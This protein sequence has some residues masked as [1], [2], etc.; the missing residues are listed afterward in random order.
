V[1]VTDPLDLQGSST[2]KFPL[3]LGSY[4]KT[5]IDAGQLEDTL[6]IPRAALREG[7][8]IWV[9][10]DDHLLKILPATILWRETETVLISN[11]LEEGDQLIVSDLRV[12]L[13]GM[14]VDPQPATASP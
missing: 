1:S 7:N 5:E 12:A 9:V 10:G 13:P 2:S 6:T 3:L 14:E 4:V 8:E 11:N